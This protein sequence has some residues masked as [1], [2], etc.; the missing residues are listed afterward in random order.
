MMLGRK[1][2]DVG[3]AM[4]V[5]TQTSHMLQRDFVTPGYSYQVI[6]CIIHFLYTI[7]DN[8]LVL[9]QIDRHWVTLSG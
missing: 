5:Y 9:V 1:V 7:F 4:A 6:V 2:A 8:C 3:R